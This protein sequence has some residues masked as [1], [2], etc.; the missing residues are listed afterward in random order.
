MYRT[1][2]DYLG[3]VIAAYKPPVKT[4]SIFYNRHIRYLHDYEVIR[5]GDF[6]EDIEAGDRAQ[7]RKDSFYGFLLGRTVEEAKQ[8]PAI[9]DVVRPIAR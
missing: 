9:L 3:T 5:E 8:M 7:V 6:V 2:T 4:P 1:D